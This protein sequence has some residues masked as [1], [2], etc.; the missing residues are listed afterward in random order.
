V[1]DDVNA[2][3]GVP[4]GRPTAAD[5][6]LPKNGLLVLTSRRL[7]VFSKA[8]MGLLSAKP[9]TADADIPL[10]EV[11]WVSE[12]V[13]VSVTRIKVVQAVVGLRSGGAV[14]ME[15]PPPAVKNGTALLAEL[16]R[17]IGATGR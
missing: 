4:I 2:R 9:K 10:A 7:L 12:P 6:H 15:F 3:R 5:V 11:D 8:A 17:R 13:E 1:A 16:G 14:R